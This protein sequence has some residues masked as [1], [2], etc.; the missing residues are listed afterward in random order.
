MG[1]IFRPDL[2]ADKVA[3]IDLSA[4]REKGF[5]FA[6]LDFDRTIPKNPFLIPMR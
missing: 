3:D 5:R 6:L 2:C 1:N 4:L